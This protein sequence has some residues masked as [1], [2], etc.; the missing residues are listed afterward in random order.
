[1]SDPSDFEYFTR[2][3][4]DDRLDVVGLLHRGLTSGSSEAALVFDGDP[5]SPARLAASVASCQAWLAQ[6]GLASGSRV[7]AMLKNS[8]GHIALIYA[9]ILSGMVWVPINT[10]LKAAGLR[11]L[12]DHSRPD[13]VVAD[14]EFAPLFGELGEL[15][16]AVVQPVSSE[17]SDGTTL[18]RFDSAPG[19]TLCLIYTSGT[20]G[21][22]K[23][24]QFTHRMLR[25]ATEAALMAADGRD[26]DR[27][28]LWEPLCHVG[29]A[30]MLLA[31]FLRRL[32]LH[33]FPGF[34]ASRFWQQAVASRATQ[35][36]Y[37]GGVLDILLQQPRTAIPAHE[38]R[39]A[40]GAGLTVQS[41]AAVREAFGVEVREC[42]GMT[43]CSSFATLNT[44]GRPGSIGKPLPWLSAEL[45]DPQGAPVANGQHGELVLSSRIAGVFLP[46]YL[47]NPQATAEALR[48][49]KLH[50]GDYAWRDADGFYYFVG[51]RTD[52]MRVRGENVSAWEVERV[53]A[54]HPA[55]AMTAAVGVTS[56]IGEQEI[57]IYLQPAEHAP[58]DR[59][60][61][62]AELA[63]WAGERLASFQV[64][65]YYQWIDRFD[66]TP[67]ERVRKHLLARGLVG[68]WDRRAQTIIERPE[69]AAD[70]EPVDRARSD[71]GLWIG[72]LPS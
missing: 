58:A 3:G 4:A 27:I 26:G 9:L 17:V 40:W 67:S 7:A 8:P 39:V 60:A 64:P 15:P 24:V 59:P 41:W 51:R 14:D 16:C 22:P 45:L 42:Y 23:G 44:E 11:Y 71:A 38:L 33:V 68:A 61:L 19:A 65:R 1:M 35:L 29:G 28:F 57:L 55:L 20:T 50:T 63:A 69:R 32:Q 72:R 6:Q 48:G 49:G 34:S 36:H 13:L 53:F 47:D 52:S 21:A 46:G 12:I 25:I 2:Q 66:L 43:E 62:A 56:E 70:G 54:L 37:L 5:W 18:Q 30:Q 10:R 31:P